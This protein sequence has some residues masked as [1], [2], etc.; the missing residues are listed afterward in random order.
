MKAFDYQQDKT[1]L[2]EYSR[3]NCEVS[4]NEC[5]WNAMAKLCALATVNVIMSCEI[6][7]VGPSKI[8]YQTN[9]LCQATWL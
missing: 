9:Y 2:S 7:K 8:E 1:A 5:N 6:K 4:L 3:E